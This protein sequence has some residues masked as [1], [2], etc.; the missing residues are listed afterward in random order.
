MPPTFRQVGGGGVSPSH[1]PCG[2]PDG[3]AP[4]LRTLKTKSRARRARMHKRLNAPIR[5]LLAPVSA[6]NGC[7]RCIKAGSRA[8]AAFGG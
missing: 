6:P 7:P 8:R 2:Y 3:I 5:R 4:F 1:L